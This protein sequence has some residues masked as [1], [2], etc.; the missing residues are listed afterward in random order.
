V[1]PAGAH[2]HAGHHDVTQGRDRLSY[3]WEKLAFAVES[4]ASSPSSLSQRLRYAWTDGL[5]NLTPHT[6]KHIPDSDLRARFEDIRDY[7]ELDPRQG[8]FIIETLGEDDQQRIARE[9]CSL[10]IRVSLQYGAE[11]EKVG[12]RRPR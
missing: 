7:F 5:M 11:K 2:L 4:M 12:R 9:I 10:Y 3:C 8:N 6:E 1:E